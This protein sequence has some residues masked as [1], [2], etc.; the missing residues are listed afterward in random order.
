MKKWLW[1]NFGL[2]AFN[3]VLLA[4]AAYFAA[5][6]PLHLAQGTVRLA[7]MR[8][9]AIAGRDSAQGALTLFDEAS[10]KQFL[11][12]GF[13]GDGAGIFT[14]HRPE[15]WT[16]KEVSIAGW[17]HLPALQVRDEQDT[18][19]AVWLNGAG[20]VG[21]QSGHL[22]FAFGSYNVGWKEVARFE[23]SGRFVVH[24]DVVIGDRSV[25]AALDDLE[26]RLER[27]EA[28]AVRQPANE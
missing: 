10:D 13:Y 23:E 5:T 14:P 21:A 27:V 25:G 7:D 11:E 22:G 4:G 3:L 6:G 20:F 15:I 24:D 2:T 26:E 9:S 8:H 18:R 12:L 28:E 19:G 17:R 1:L 16:G